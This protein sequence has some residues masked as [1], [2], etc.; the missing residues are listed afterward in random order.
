MLSKIP[1][2][3]VAIVGAAIVV[4]ATATSSTLL[5]Q[6]RESVQ[7]ISKEIAESRRRVDRLWSNHL[8]ADRQ[9]IAGDLL[10]AQAMS[11]N[12][13]P[14][15][16]LERAA[17]YL[18][19]ATLAMWIASGKHEA[20]TMEEKLL[21]FKESLAHGD[22][23]GYEQFKLKINQLRELSATNINGHTAELRAAESRIES[24]QSRESLLY[25]AYVFFNLLGLMV[26]MCK[27]L[28][29]WKSERGREPAA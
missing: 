24:L 11:E 29:V 17:Y 23:R 9:S 19:S 6:T 18:W 2:W 28:P 26:T 5:H 12:G 10:Y 8:V 16:I 7:E 27:D 1:S 4:V 15:F 13:K 25:M 21:R 20:E 14:E 22:I 3:V